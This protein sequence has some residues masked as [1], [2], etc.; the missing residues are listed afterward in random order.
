[1]FNNNITTSCV[2]VV[3]SSFMMI[4]DAYTLQRQQQCQTM[5]PIT[6]FHVDRNMERTKIRSKFT[7]L[8]F[9]SPE[10]TPND[11]GDTNDDMTLSSSSSSS[12]NTASSSTLNINAPSFESSN[13]FVRATQSDAQDAL[14][15]VGWSLPTTT[16]STSTAVTSMA[17]GDLTSDDPFVQMIDQSIQKDVGVSL[18][19]LLNPAKVVNLERDLYL[20]RTQLAQLTGATTSSSSSSS[21]QQSYTFL[22]TENCDNGGGGTEA[23]EIRKIIQ[24]KEA[25]LM[26]E[27]RSVFRNWLK[28]V[29]LIQAVISFGL[30]YVMASNSALLFGQFD[31]YLNPKYNMDI[32]I[33]VL[34]Y[35]WWWL[36]V[37]PSLR[38]RRPKG[39]EKQALDIA[40][41]A[42]P[43]ISLL[44]PI[45]TKDTTLI[46]YAN[47]LVVAGA[48]GFA[49]VQEQQQNSNGDD[50]D[51][52]LN[53]SKQPE[54]LKF[55]YKSLDFGTGRE[56]GARN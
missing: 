56:R 22:T 28:N 5:L 16:T 27:R 18:D 49:Y 11:D 20:Y 15:A 38:S 52:D 32:S 40:F 53:A 46:W 34:G 1:M 9:S 8:L 36:F 35:W 14:N 47:F 48:Y 13:E 44:A 30:S 19:D 29:F 54:W 2:V 43:I 4:C 21:Q 45:A 55:V 25:D 12:S 33:S 42:S 31:W 39:F 17:D 23:E 50:D 41:L 24:K 10:N 51:D 26:I 3:I 6:S 37:I 7:A